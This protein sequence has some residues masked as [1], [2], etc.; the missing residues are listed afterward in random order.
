M[1]V[2]MKTNLSI[3]FLS[4]LSVAFS[5]KEQSDHVWLSDQITQMSFT[6]FTLYSM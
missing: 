1:E 4:F 2:T 3:R 5:H 6:P